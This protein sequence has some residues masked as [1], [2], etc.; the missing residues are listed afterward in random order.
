M[1]HRPS[2]PGRGWKDAPHPFSSFVWCWWF[3]RLNI[4]LKDVECRCPIFRFLFCHGSMLS[5]WRRHMG[6]SYGGHQRWWVGRS[7]GWR[8]GPTWTV[9]LTIPSAAKTRRTNTVPSFYS[10]D[11]AN[12][13][14]TVKCNEIKSIT[15]AIRHNEGKI[16]SLASSTAVNLFLMIL[17]FGSQLTTSKTS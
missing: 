6:L 7:S 5:L 4:I 2:K 9:R 10:K 11:S 13:Y 17:I 12:W 1:W 14:Y 8:L 15:S 16:I 3:T